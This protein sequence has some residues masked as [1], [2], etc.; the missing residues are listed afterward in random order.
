MADFLPQEHVA[1]FAQMPFGSIH[2]SIHHCVKVVGLVAK[3][4]HPPSRPQHVAGTTAVAIVIVVV[5]W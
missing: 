5:D 3:D 2:V 1:S 4:S